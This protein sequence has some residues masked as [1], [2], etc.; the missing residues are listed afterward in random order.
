MFFLFVALQCCSEHWL[1]LPVGY[2]N[3]AAVDRGKP[4]VYEKLTGMSR[5]TLSRRLSVEQAARE[6]SITAMEGNS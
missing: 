5:K 4:H 1:R 2:L 6:L 3:E